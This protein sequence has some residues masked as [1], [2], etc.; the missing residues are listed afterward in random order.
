M[1]AN[2]RVKCGGKSPIKDVR[3]GFKHFKEPWKE[4]L[5]DGLKE[6][7]DKRFEK[8]PLTEKPAIDK[9]HIYDKPP[10]SEGKYTDGKLTETS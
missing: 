3:D 8:L 5:K 4:W 10:V 1:T 2:V 9:L 7:L 6:G